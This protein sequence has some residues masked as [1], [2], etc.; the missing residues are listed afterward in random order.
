MVFGAILQT[1]HSR[2]ADGLIYGALVPEPSGFAALGK[3]NGNGVYPISLKIIQ[4]EKTNS[5]QRTQ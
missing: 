4:Q 5:E 3:T 2:M 1:H